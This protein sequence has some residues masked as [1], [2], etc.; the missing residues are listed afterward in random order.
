MTR[1]MVTFV[2]REPVTR[3]LRQHRL[4]TFFDSR[5]FW[6]EFEFAWILAIK[7]PYIRCCL[8]LVRGTTKS[9]IFPDQSGDHVHVRS[10]YVDP[11]RSTLRFTQRG[12]LKSSAR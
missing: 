6:D 3:F 12:K 11:C 9:H 1:A 10:S 2:K 4:A 8:S 5:D 7:Q